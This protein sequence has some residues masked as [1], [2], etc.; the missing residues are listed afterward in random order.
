MKLEVR[1]EKLQWAIQKLQK[2]QQKQLS[3]PILEAIY[4]E[5]KENTL[6]LRTTNLHVGTEV[7]IPV[8][9]EQEGKV[10]V[11]YDLLSQVLSNLKTKE[12]KIE[13]SFDGNLFTVKTPYSQVNMTSYNADE[14]PTL[15]KIADAPSF[16]LPIT[17][18]IDGVQSVMYAAAQ[19][20]I[21]PEIS[22]VYIYTDGNELV[23]VSTDSFRLAEKRV[24]VEN[25]GDFPGVIFPIKN[26]Q[27][28]IRVFAREEG[29][30][31]VLVSENQ[32]SFET[33]SLYFVSRVIDGTY[34]NYQQ[35]IPTESTTTIT[36]LHS[37]LTSALR[38]VHIF[39]D[40]FH[41]IFLRTEKEREKVIFSAKNVEVG[42]SEAEV[43]AH[44]QGED[45]E[46]KFNYR[47][48]YDVLSHQ[49]GDSISIEL[50][51]TR[52]PFV[53]RYVGE[54]SFLYLIMPMR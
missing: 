11:R 19:T 35:I 7:V 27:E 29:N 46:I 54:P 42:E 30:F 50:T 43:D 31:S 23:F 6:I 3:L 20:D 48:L 28:F 53:V 25:V 12:D 45:I 26:V 44:I 8:K 49:M 38:L 18:F 17:D 15:P 39:S 52:K 4:L 10:A 36:L 9:V 51:E 34:P 24:V 22:S 21:K 37:E 13:F 1:A 41:Q 2:N 40:D 47:Y 5:A 33:E 16:T 14:F 32:I